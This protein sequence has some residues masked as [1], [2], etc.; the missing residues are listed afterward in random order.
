MRVVYEYDKNGK[1]Y[2]ND[3]ALNDAIIELDDEPVNNCDPSDYIDFESIIKYDVTEHD[4]N[5]FDTFKMWC[6]QENIK[7]S[8]ASSVERYWKEVER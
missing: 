4:A 8:H 2:L 1:L 7:P 3:G 6:E 5:S